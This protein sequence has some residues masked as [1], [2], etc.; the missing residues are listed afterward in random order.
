M[1][2][3]SY[4]WRMSF[5][6]IDGHPAMY[7]VSQSR[8]RHTD[9]FLGFLFR[10]G[11]PVH[12]NPASFFSILFNILPFLSSSMLLSFGSSEVLSSS[13]PI[14]QWNERLVDE[15][16]LNL[17]YFCQSQIIRLEFRIL[18]CYRGLAQCHPGLLKPDCQILVS[19]T[20]SGHRGSQSSDTRVT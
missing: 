15:I 19:P 20:G 1:R 5:K 11:S 16:L 17:D 8:P 3:E 18:E 10:I 4:A 7:E 9:A 13:T 12:S 14:L 6:D 2:S